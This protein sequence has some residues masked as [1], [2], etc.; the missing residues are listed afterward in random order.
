MKKW[1]GCSSPGLV[2][3]GV[4]VLGFAVLGPAVAESQILVI[5]GIYRDSFADTEANLCHGSG[6]GCAECVFIALS[7]GDGDGEPVDPRSRNLAVA[8]YTP[9]LIQAAEEP[10]QPLSLAVN[11]GLPF[12][13]P[14]QSGC[15]APALFDRVRERGRE[16][17]PATAISAT[18]KERSRNRA[19]PQVTAR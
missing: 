4:F 19:H 15:K 6:S 17:V 5:C 8:S 9:R 18:A 11:T 1:I 7:T 10:D 3:A 16:L 12:T 14:G 2:R 13:P